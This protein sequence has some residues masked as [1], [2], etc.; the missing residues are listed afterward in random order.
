MNLNGFVLELKK[1]ETKRL[2]K[3][4]ALIEEGTLSHKQWSELETINLLRGIFRFGEN[5]WKLILKEENFDKSRTV[6]QL[7]LKWR[8]IKIFMKGELDAMNVKRQ[9]LITK[10]NWII[11]AIKGLEK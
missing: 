5:N 1:Y 6:N 8:M 9:K 7:I 3:L 10:E 2:K 11:A 4:G